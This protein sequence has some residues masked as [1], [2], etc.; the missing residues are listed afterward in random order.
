MSETTGLD[1]F[2]RADTSTLAHAVKGLPVAWLAS[3]VA[4]GIGIILRLV[5][6]LES[7]SLSLDEAWLALNITNRSFDDLFGQLD[8]NQAA[9]PAFLAVDKT[10]VEALGDSEYSLR[11]LPFLAG[12]LA[13]VLIPFLAHRVVGAPGV[14]ARRRALRA[15]RSADLLHHVEQA[16]CGRRPHRHHY[17]VGRVSLWRPSPRG[18]HSVGVCGRRS[19]RDLAIT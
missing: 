5:E 18:V 17:L 19:N 10:I 3:L 1:R 9:P 13:L 11:L 14:P 8:F 7:R 15:F 6:L 16:V 4:V 12:T 2:W